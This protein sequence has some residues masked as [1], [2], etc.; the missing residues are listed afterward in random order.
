MDNYLLLKYIHIICAVILSGTGAGIAFFMLMAS[1][2]KNIPAIAVTARHVVLADWIFTTPAVIGQFATGVLL[3]QH[4]HYNF[5]SI[6]FL[7]VISLFLF[8]GFCWIP[9]V[10]IQYKIKRLAEIAEITGNIS[11]GF[12]MAMKW[13]VA[14]G[15]PAFIGVLFML[16]LMIF[17]PFPVI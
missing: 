13:W 8:I 17:K 12:Y 4:L 10:F 6:W 2:T 1:R 5:T 15:I 11:N 3:M 7:S 9:V 16:W 14:L